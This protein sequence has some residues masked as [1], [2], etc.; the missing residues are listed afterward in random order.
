MHVL[1]NSQRECQNSQNNIDKNLTSRGT[2]PAPLGRPIYVL[3]KY[4]GDKCRPRYIHD[5]SEFFETFCPT[6]ENNRISDI[7]TVR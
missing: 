5:G 3:S 2:P 4:S 6:I 7:I 1:S